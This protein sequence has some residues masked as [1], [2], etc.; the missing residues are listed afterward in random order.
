MHGSINRLKSHN[1]YV[2]ADNSLILIL[3]SVVLD[4]TH[5]TEICQKLHSITTMHTF[6]KAVLL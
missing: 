2:L 6:C 4:V 3:K 1:L 5:V